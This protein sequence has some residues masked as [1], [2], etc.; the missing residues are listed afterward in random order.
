MPLFFISAKWFRSVVW[1]SLQPESMNVDRI[2]ESIYG[3]PRPAFKE[4]AFSTMGR[5]TGITRADLS[6]LSTSSLPLSGC[7]IRKEMYSNS[8]SVSMEIIGNVSLSAKDV[9]NLAGFESP[10]IN[11]IK[12]PVSIPTI[13]LSPGYAAIQRPLQQT[14]PTCPGSAQIE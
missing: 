2:I 1:I 9:Q 11:P 7:P 3:M 10:F 13:D 5:S 14:V 12:K 6:M 8:P 4:A